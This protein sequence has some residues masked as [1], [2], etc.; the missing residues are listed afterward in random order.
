MQSRSRP[1]VHWTRRDRGPHVPLHADQGP[2]C[3]RHVVLLKHEPTSR[4]FAPEHRPSTLHETSLECVPVPQ[5]RLQTPQAE[6]DHA[7]PEVFKHCCQV[8]GLSPLHSVCFLPAAISP[9]QV[10]LRSCVPDP[11]LEVHADHALTFQSQ[12]SGR[13]QLWRGAGASPGQ[14]SGR[15]PGHHTCRVRYPPPQTGHSDQL[16]VRQRQP[17]VSSHDFDSE[18]RSKDLQSASTPLLHLTERV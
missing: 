11:Q 5:L 3:H 15:V 6:V 12:P 7:Q 9:L 17:R 13:T 14:S 16:E 10:T 4:G 8:N 2:M 18:D 1:V